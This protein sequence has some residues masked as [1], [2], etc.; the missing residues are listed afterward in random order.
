MSA[1][2]D[3]SAG[4]AW[5]EGRF[6]PIAEARIPILDR[7]F[8]RSDAT[9]DVT[10]VWK[11]F[12]F[13]LE[14]H[15]DRFERNIA[16]LRLELP[17]SREEL[18]RILIECVRI[19]GL[20][21]AFLQMT[22]TRGLTPRGSRDPRQAEN[23]L[24]VFAVP[25]VWIADR[26]KQEQ[27]L[28]LHISGIERIPSTSLDPRTKNFHWL[29]LT[30]GLFEAYDAGCDIEVLS[31]RG[32]NVTEGPGFNIFVLAGGRL[33]TPREGVFDGMTRRT[34]LELA[35][36][37]NVRAEETIVPADLVR[38]AEE[39]FLTSTAGGIMPVT[40]IDGEKVGD[41]RP[42]PLTRRLRELYWSKK[43]KGWLGTPIDYRATAA[44]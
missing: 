20:K 11:G 22:L 17:C 44:A 31:D 42:G 37:T 1:A 6:V 13:R 33:L 21:D 25:F 7:G 38:R 35:G 8:T 12:I 9:Y 28:N 18:R 29:D 5:I 43:E 15:L 19:T 23:R 36:E 41:G 4:A 24:Y 34:V 10:H 39:V 32:G 40:A 27:G 14:D 3:F 16:A 2:P 30:L 26:E